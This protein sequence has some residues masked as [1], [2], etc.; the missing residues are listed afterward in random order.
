MSPAATRTGTR[1]KRAASTRST[2]NGVDVAAIR[3]QMYGLDMEMSG[4]RL[5]YLD[6][7]ATT[8]RLKASIE[9]MSDMHRNE[10]A[11]IHQEGFPLARQAKKT[12][13]GAREAVAKFV[14]AKRP[15]EIVWV[16]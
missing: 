10:N 6:A 8:Q 7:A 16:H 5:V 12:Y 4:R 14:G 15:E 13:D 11:N 2:T 9:A 1:A 3:S